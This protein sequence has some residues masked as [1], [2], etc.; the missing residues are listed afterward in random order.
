MHPGILSTGIENRHHWRWPSISFW[1]RILGKLACP[2]NNLWWI[3]ARI[4]KFTSKMNLE[5]LLTGIDLDLDL[6]GHWVISN[7]DSNK[8]HSI[9]LMY[10]DLGQPRHVTRPSVLLLLFY[11]TNISIMNTYAVSEMLQGVHSQGKSQG[12]SSLIG[13]HGKV[14]EILKS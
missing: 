10:F 1:L 5:I 4:T 9:L 6:H 12:N 2:G 14:R 13:S 7:Q 3:W 11:L 8:Q